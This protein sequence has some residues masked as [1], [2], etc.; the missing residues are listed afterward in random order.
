MSGAKEELGLREVPSEPRLGNLSAQGNLAPAVGRSRAQARKV[1][2]VGSRTQ[3]GDAPRGRAARC[4]SANA[5]TERA[6]KRAA[7]LACSRCTLA[8]VMG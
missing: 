5:E 2:T 7:E 3:T 8:M 1:T 6:K 4:W